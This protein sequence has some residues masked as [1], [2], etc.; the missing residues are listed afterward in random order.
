MSLGNKLRCLRNKHN[1]TQEQLA[2]QFHVTR[3]T[4][5]EWELD[6]MLPETAKLLEIAEFFDTSLDEL[7]LDKEDASLRILR[8]PQETPNETQQPSIRL[9]TLQ[10][11]QIGG[12]I[13][14]TALLLW[15]PAKNAAH[16]S[17]MNLIDASFILILALTLALG[18]LFKGLFR[19]KAR[20][21]R[22]IA[23][24][25][26]CIGFGVSLFYFYALLRSGNI[27]RGVRI[28]L[29]PLYYGILVGFA[30][31]FGDR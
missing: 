16:F 10:K 7:L 31:G 18:L 12:I 13:L 17:P 26:V 5:S 30:A 20:L 25:A 28:A 9:S 14:L 6:Q 11:L 8:E 19:R 1:L 21:S 2:E 22:L 4:I 27:G 15:N 29:L 24:L 3:Q 23:V